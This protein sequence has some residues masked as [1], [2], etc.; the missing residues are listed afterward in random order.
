M[1]IVTHTYM[2]KPFHTH[3]YIYIY[4]T[5]FMELKWCDQPTTNI[6]PNKKNYYYEYCIIQLCESDTF[7]FRSEL[8]KEK[9]GEVN[10]ELMKKHMRR[11]WQ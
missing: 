7:Y 10:E 6:K 4:T 8:N 9:Q 3:I 2:Y 5:L 11:L 1:C